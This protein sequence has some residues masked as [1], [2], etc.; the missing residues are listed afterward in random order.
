MKKRLR[1]HGKTASMPNDVRSF[2]VHRFFSDELIA[3]HQGVMDRI[4]RWDLDE[5]GRAMDSWDQVDCFVVIVAGPA[6]HA[7][8]IKDADVKSWAL[9]HDRWWRPTR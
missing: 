1:A 2:I 6:L 4:A 3:N 8:R 5:P 9:S 7:G